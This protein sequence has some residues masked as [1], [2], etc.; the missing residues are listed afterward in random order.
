MTALEISMQDYFWLVDRLE[1]EDD[2]RNKVNSDTQTVT[3]GKQLTSSLRNG[4]VFSKLLQKMQA[5][6]AKR[7]KKFFH[8]N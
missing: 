8:L 7:T 3:L 1:L 4:F 6:Y 5:T 2:P